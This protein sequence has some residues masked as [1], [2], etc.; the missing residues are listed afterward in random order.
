MFG[1]AFGGFIV[2]GLTIWVLRS[3]IPSLP[4]ESVTPPADNIADWRS[5]AVIAIGCLVFLCFLLIR[6]LVSRTS[7]MIQ[8]RAKET[9]KT[10]REKNKTSRKRWIIG[11]LI[12]ALFLAYNGVDECIRYYKRFNKADRV[13]TGYVVESDPGTPGH[14]G[15]DGDPGDPAWSHYQFKVDGKTYDGG[16]DYELAQGETIL[17]RYNSSDPSFN[18][19]QDDD[20]SMFQTWFGRSGFLLVIVLVFLV[21]VIR[22]RREAE[23]P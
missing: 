9:Q 8:R 15:P 12:L 19:A 2:G 22:N 20:R 10:E 23:Y 6:F 11:L 14:S 7:W 1:I 4:W 18:H 17:V 3:L 21:S 13:A 16:T 5:L